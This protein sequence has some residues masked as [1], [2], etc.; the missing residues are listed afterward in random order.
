MISDA[1][2]SASDVFSSLIVIVGLNISGKKS[3]SDHQYGHERLE[4]IASFFLSAIL[5][6]TGATIGYGGLQKIFLAIKGDFGLADIPIPTSLPL[7][8]AIVSIGIKE[9]MYW[10]TRAV[11]KRVN[12]SSL[13]AD[14]WHHRSDAFSSIGSLIG[15]AGAKLGFPILDPIAS[16]VICVA[17]IKA[18]YDICKSALSQMVDK[19]CSEE[20]TEGIR[21]VIMS[22]EGVKTVDLLM[23]RLFGSKFYVDIEISVDGNQPLRDAHAISQKVHDEVEKKYPLAKHCMVHMNPYEADEEG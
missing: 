19:S 6:L 21:E 1:I 7:I 12:S 4:C 17:I 9:A 22:V 15:I 2:H 13:M 3:D 8:A 18:A 20:T 10:Y 11:A 5:F 16:V 23:T 14:A